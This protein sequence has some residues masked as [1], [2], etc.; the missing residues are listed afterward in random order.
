MP[1]PS[2]W[3]LHTGI[4]LL[5]PGLRRNVRCAAITSLTSSTLNCS[6]NILLTCPVFRPPLSTTHHWA[7]KVA[8]RGSDLNGFLVLRSAFC[9]RRA[10]IVSIRESGVEPNHAALY[11]LECN[12]LRSLSLPQCKTTHTRHMIEDWRQH[13]G[14]IRTWHDFN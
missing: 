13:A 8:I 5:A 14:L 4:F 9:R 11:E 1:A 6:G 12:M 2:Y 10:E 7:V 3:L